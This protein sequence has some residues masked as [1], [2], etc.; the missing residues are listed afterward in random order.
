MPGWVPS[1]VSTRTTTVMSAAPTRA[2]PM[3][4]IPPTTAITTYSIDS[5]TGNEPGARYPR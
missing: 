1:V 4:P 2:P 5:S 3:L